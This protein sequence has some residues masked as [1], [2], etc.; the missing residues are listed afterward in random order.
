[1]T[2]DPGVRAAAALG[3]AVTDAPCKLMK[4]AIAFIIKIKNRQHHIIT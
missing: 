2:F 3:P 1:M 4:K